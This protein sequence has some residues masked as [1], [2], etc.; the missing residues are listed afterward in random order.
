MASFV[1]RNATAM[2]PRS[3]FLMPTAI[4]SQSIH[5]HRKIVKRS[6]DT[7]AIWGGTCAAVATRS[8]R[9]TENKSLGSPSSLP[10]EQLLPL[11]LPYP[12]FLCIARSTVVQREKS[13]ANTNSAAQGI[14]E[15]SLRKQQLLFI[16][17]LWLS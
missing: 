4:P 14:E 12:S 7:F 15:R 9:G 17:R 1:S 13:T 2:R 10:V 8:H 11:N 5:V 3:I 6:A 16:L